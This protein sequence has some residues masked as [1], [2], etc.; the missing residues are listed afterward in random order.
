MISNIKLSEKI[1]KSFYDLWRAF[2]MEQ[3]I[4]YYATGGRAGSKSTTFCIR[5]VL[6]RMSTN[7]HGLGVR[8]YATNLRKTIRNQCIWAI[9]HLEV[10]DYWKWSDKP[11]ADMTLE[12]I[13]TGAKIF[14]EGADGE[15]VKGWKTPDMPTTDIFFDE[16]TNYKTDEDL[17]SLVLSILRE[18]LPENYQYNFFYAFNPAKSKSHWANK[19]VFTHTLPDNTFHHHS[20]Y[21]TNPFLPEAFI[22]EA[23]HVRDTNERRYKWEFLG[24]PIGS[25]MEP[26]DNLEFRK[27]TLDELISFDNF[28]LGN[29][30]GYSVDPNAFVVWHYDKT[31]KRIYAVDEHYQT[32][33]SISQLADIIKDK[34]WERY[35]IIADSSEPRSVAEL[36]SYGILVRGAKKGKGSVEHGE[37]WLGDL[38]AIVI[39]PQLTPNLAREFENA[40]YIVDKNG[41]TIPRLK[42]EDNHGIDGTRYAFENDM[43]M[44][45]WTFS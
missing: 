20:D 35:N 36:R 39:D 15:K 32:K 14:F 31:R 3:F 43:R 21:R 29:D 2:S 40:D 33:L 25:G 16:I 19:K 13:P 28:R 44:N 12:Y 5:M 41:N 38:E 11:T 17:S 34:G 22:T 42:D 8:K 1:L 18:K 37:K 10:E 30:W 6:N 23:E 9:Y 4:H 26:F 27:I 7:T 24:E 45:G